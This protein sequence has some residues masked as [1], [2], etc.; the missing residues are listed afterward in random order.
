MITIKEYVAPE[1]I[2]EA[3][4][5]LIS[6][7]NNLILGGCGFIKM[8]SK[9]IGTAID[10][11]NLNL[12]YIQENEE[13]IV[14][15]ADT[16]LRSLEVNP[17]IKD[18]CGG[19]ISQGVSNIVGVQFRNMA[20]IGASVFS[21]YG[22]SDLLPSLLVLDAKVILC[23]GG[24]I[25]LKDFLDK[26]Y[27]KDI[28]IEVI[29][30]KKEGVAVSDCLR[31]SSTDFPIINGA[32]FKG[33]NGEYKIAIGSRPQR[34]KLAEKSGEALEKGENIEKV[35]DMVI[36]ELHIGANIR[37]T[38]EY[39]EDMCKALVNRMYHKIGDYN[40]R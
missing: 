14:I 4:K 26:E 31:K 10:L 11:C 27:E 29:L 16:S 23:N 38:K 32:M 28:L 17:I 13:E 20:R 8:G 35:S 1:S 34:G 3:Y 21:R 25:E 18:Y 9:N 2:E 7:R 22:F 30:P 24:T 12:D 36:E 5:I 37:G 19:A 33:K 40:D 15:G 39:R 6:K